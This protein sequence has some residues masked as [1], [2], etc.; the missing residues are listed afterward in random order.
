[1]TYF[2]LYVNILQNYLF[3]KK[4]LY[5]VKGH[6]DIKMMKVMKMSKSQYFIDRNIEIYLIDG[7]S[8]ITRVERYF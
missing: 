4:L 6:F 5:S 2:N 3:S 1:M 8:K 7:I